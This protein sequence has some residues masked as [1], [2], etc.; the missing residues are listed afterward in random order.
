MWGRVNTK[1]EG[2][3]TRYAG[4]GIQVCKRWESFEAFLE[5]MGER[6]PLTSLDRV[7]NTRGYEPGNCR[8][9][10]RQQQQRNMRSNVRVTIDGLT[11]CLAEWCD[12]IGVGENTVGYR[13]KNGWTPFEA[14]FTPVGVSRDTLSRE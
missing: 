7:D 2:I 5:D 8:W 9:A 6:V 12:M 13:L 10:T 3:R 4:R 14:V 11:L 1:D